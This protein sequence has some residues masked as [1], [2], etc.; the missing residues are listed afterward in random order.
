MIEKYLNDT[1]KRVEIEKKMLEGN[2]IQYLAEEK[3]APK[4]KKQKATDQKVATVK[5]HKHK[6]E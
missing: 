2:T 5:K 1:I 6:D 3:T 4:K